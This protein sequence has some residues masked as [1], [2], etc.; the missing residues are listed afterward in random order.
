VRVVNFTVYHSFTGIIS[1][2]V[3]N[4]TGFNPVADYKRLGST[5]TMLGVMTFTSAGMISGL[6]ASPLA[7]KLISVN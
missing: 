5:P 3:E 2:A 1:D 4:M 6:F 7:C